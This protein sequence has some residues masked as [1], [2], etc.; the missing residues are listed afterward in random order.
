MCQFVVIDVQCFDFDQIVVLCVFCI[1]WIDY[2][3]FVMLVNWQYVVVI[4]G[5]YFED[6]YVGIFLFVE[7]FDDL[8]GIGWVVVIVGWENFGEYVVV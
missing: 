5:C 8:C 7:N 2:Q 4:V 1:I 3:F 6:V